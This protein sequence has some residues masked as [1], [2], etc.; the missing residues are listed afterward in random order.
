MRDEWMPKNVEDFALHLT[1]LRTQR[2]E[3]K[4]SAKSPNRM[5]HTL[6]PDQRKAILLKTDG[7]CHVCGGAIEG[8]WQADHVL[9]HS[10]GGNDSAENYLPAHGTC[11]NYRWDYLP[12]EFQEILRM[13]VWLRTQ[14]ERQTRI[15]KLAGVVFIAH[16]K[17]RLGRRT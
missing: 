10:G 14:L 11:N 17:R 15:G 1:Q 16:E 8:T 12:E 7:R 6:S 13:G 5:R 3:L 4:G 2:E 9:A